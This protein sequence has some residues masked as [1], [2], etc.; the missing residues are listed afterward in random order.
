M[1][2]VIV[3]LPHQ[4][5]ALGTIRTEQSRQMTPLRNA[6]NLAPAVGIARGALSLAPLA[7]IA[8]VER[9]AKHAA[10]GGLAVLSPVEGLERVSVAGAYIGGSG[11]V[12]GTVGVLAEAVVV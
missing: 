3:P 9:D 10:I 7:P 2:N 6:L 1:S 11:V 5:K 8:V 4:C 12:V